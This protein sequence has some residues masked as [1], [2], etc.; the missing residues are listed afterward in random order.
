MTQHYVLISSRDGTKVKHELYSKGNS[1]EENVKY[2]NGAFKAH[3]KV[4]EAHLAENSNLVEI[5]TTLTFK[6][7]SIVG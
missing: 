2:A 7:D 6:T 1:S 5:V 3:M 4:D